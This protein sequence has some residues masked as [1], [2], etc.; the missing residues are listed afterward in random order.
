M[1][2][3]WCPEEKQVSAIEMQWWIVLSLT[4]NG[5]LEKRK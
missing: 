3:P 1:E 5:Q 2:G 4:P